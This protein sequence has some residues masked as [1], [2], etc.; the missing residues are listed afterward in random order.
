MNEPGPYSKTEK[1]NFLMAV[2]G[3]EGVLGNPSRR[4]MKIWTEGGTTL[5]KFYE[6]IEEILMDIG[7][8]GPGNWVCFTMDNLNVH[9]NPGVL[10]LIH[11]YGHGVCFRAPYY[12]IDGPIEYIF[13]TLQGL[14]RSRLY[15]IY[16]SRSLLAV[17]SQSIQS[18]NDFSCYFRCCGFIHN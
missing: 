15:E 17:I 16:D 6:F 4:W 3:E 1:W 13:N 9:K 18:I 10:A 14:I 11:A 2:C 12:A 8:A 5:E 7:P